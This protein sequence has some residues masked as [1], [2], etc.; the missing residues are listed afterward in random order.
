MS[1]E[2]FQHLAAIRVHLLVLNKWLMI[3]WKVQLFIHWPNE[4]YEVAIR[5]MKNR[6]T[7]IPTQ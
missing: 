7:V 3:D 2:H 4:L 1:A 6:D 5:I